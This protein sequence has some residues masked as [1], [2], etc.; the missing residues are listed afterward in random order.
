MSKTNQQP[1]FGDNLAGHY[2]S[3]AADENAESSTREAAMLF[4]VAEGHLDADNFVEG[5]RVGREALELFKEVGNLKAAADASR[6]V[7]NAYCAL[8]ERKEANRLAREMKEFFES[9]EGSEKGTYWLGVAKMLLSIAEVNY[10]KRGSKNREVARESALQALSIFKK[11]SDTKMEAAT[12]MVLCNI[13]M[14]DKKGSKEAHG[15]QACEYAKQA[16]ELF[17]K[18]RDRK[19]EA[20]SLHNLAAAFV[21]MRDIS[22]A[23]KAS[24]MALN[25][26]RELG[27]K[28]LEAYEL[29]C[30][31]LWQSDVQ[32]EAALSSAEAALAAS[33]E[34]DGSGGRGLEASALGTL[35]RMQGETDP[36]AALKAA[37]SGLRRFR[38]LEDKE[39]EAHALTAVAS[40]RQ[41]TDP[42]D[43]LTLAARA[44]TAFKALGDA[45]GETI[46]QRMI[47]EL[48]IRVQRGDKALEAAAGSL[49]Q[50][51]D[52]RDSRE[53]ASSMFAVARVYL[54]RGEGDKVLEYTQDA[55][56]ICKAADWKAGEAEALVLACR[57]HA[58]LEQLEDSLEAAT[59]AKELLRSDGDVPGEAAV[60]SM[61]CE[62]KILQE[63]FEAAMKTAGELKEVAVKLSDA[64]LQVNALLL[65]TRAGVKHLQQRMQ[66]DPRSV[67]PSDPGAAATFATANEALSLS[68]L[69]RDRQLVASAQYMLAEMHLMAFDAEAALGATFESASLSQKA[70]DLQGEASALQLSGNAHLHLK[71]MDAAW[72]CASKALELHQRCGNSDG[73]E[74]AAEFLEMIWPYWAK[75]EPQRAA[76]NETDDGSNDIVVMAAP[77]KAAIKELGKRDAVDLSSG[78]GEEM[79]RGKI[80]GVLTDNLSLD[81]DDFEQDT[82]MMESGLTSGGAILLQSALSVDFP[83]VKLPATLIFDYPSMRAVIAF[84]I[85][86]IDP[87]TLAL[88]G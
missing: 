50:S 56:H 46:V 39:G 59:S 87:S 44:Q 48:Q 34:L 45:R 7:G 28:K 61:I 29:Q 54:A 23:L 71:E 30:A 47:S 74:V 35:V 16:W 31:A 25:L 36:E 88:A 51:A 52:C 77:K 86:A 18:I 27:D 38:E 26:F 78:I 84:I 80:L 57:A 20:L 73:A 65:A 17:R 40:A 41:N 32:P 55:Q 81:V 62:I 11:E 49:K 42:R 1:V 70:G 63:E 53:I 33:R 72:D 60:I 79:I 4:A 9:A 19:Q 85:N 10:D 69:L 8:E 14:K 21:A 5:L 58:N 82:P 13:T 12:L 43:A 6:L 64:G 66:E 76:V 83:T 3:V 75:K 24:N 37:K 22:R 68:R 2:S 15:Q 67:A